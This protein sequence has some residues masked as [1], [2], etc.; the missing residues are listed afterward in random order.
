MGP[1]E[2]HVQVVLSRGHAA[3][4]EPTQEW[5]VPADQL[6]V[7]QLPVI[8]LPIARLPVARLPVAR[9]TVVADRR[10]QASDPVAILALHRVASRSR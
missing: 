8:R 6:P 5:N 9:P 4:H 7:V 10:G 3:I 2:F 1:H